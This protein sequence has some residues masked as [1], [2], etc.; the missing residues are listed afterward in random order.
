LFA[1]LALLV[2][3][4][5]VTHVHRVLLR[6]TVFG[7]DIVVRGGVVMISVTCGGLAAVAFLVVGFS[8][9][10]TLFLVVAF[11]VESLDLLALVATVD[12]TLGLDAFLG[13]VEGFRGVRI[14]RVVILPDLPVR[15]VGFY[16][17]GDLIDAV[18]DLGLFPDEFLDQFI[19]ASP[20][21][22]T[23]LLGGILGLPGGRRFFID[24][25]VEGV[26]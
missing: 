24:R 6:V 5:L 11:R 19:G 9:V 17:V 4:Q 2:A 7:V 26:A 21:L 10:V 1:G 8:V 3:I 20:S 12:F 23:L 16:R 22:V 18:V 25:V 13:V 15:V 14:S